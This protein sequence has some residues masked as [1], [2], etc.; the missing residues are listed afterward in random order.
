MDGLAFLGDKRLLSLILNCSQSQCPD[1]L[2]SNSHSRRDGTR[3]V[4]KSIVSLM[5]DLPIP[6]IKHI[7]SFFLLNYGYE[8]QPEQNLN[9][10][11]IPQGGILGFQNLGSQR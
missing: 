6:V 5:W 7:F 11:R 4:V 1:R 8:L 10:H 2:L 3:T 9:Q